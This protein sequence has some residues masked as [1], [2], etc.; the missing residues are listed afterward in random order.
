MDQD[1]EVEAFALPPSSPHAVPAKRKRH[2]K[3]S[4]LPT[5]VD[6][7]EVALPSKPKNKRAKLAKG[8]HEPV[9]DVKDVASVVDAFNDAGAGVE[10]DT[11][12]NV[13][14]AGPT[15]I[16]IKLPKMP[17]EAATTTA[18]IMDE[19]VEDPEAGDVAAEQVEIPRLRQLTDDSWDTPPPREEERKD[20]AG[21]GNVPPPQSD[22]N[23]PSNSLSGPSNVALPPPPSLPGTF[24]QQ[25][26][27]MLRILRFKGDP[28]VPF[29]NSGSPP[30]SH[31]LTPPRAVA[32]A[33]VRP[34]AA[35]WTSL[36]TPETEHTRSNARFTPPRSQEDETERS[37][38]G[39]GGNSRA[40][41][42]EPGHP[43]SDSPIDAGEHDPFPGHRTMFTTDHP[44]YRDG[45]PLEY[46]ADPYDNPEIQG[47]YKTAFQ[48]EPPKKKQVKK[49]RAIRPAS[50]L[51]VGDGSV[52]GSVLDRS[53]MEHEGTPAGTENGE[54]GASVKKKRRV[55]KPP[56]AD[57]PNSIGTW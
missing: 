53:G 30:I 42:E 57:D 47:Q 10:D 24:A 27:N 12:S 18:M 38:L 4:T 54:A 23:P 31:S 19:L 6:G 52:D 11:E 29:V 36:Q 20:I 26:M 16:R 9:A 33:P 43:R 1:E 46:E 17:V 14:T 50:S 49:K 32:H 22:H 35:D 21:I 44:N 51:D 28:N 25:R 5:A 15:T 41:S 45:T 48:P 2:S 40:P 8:P 3:S 7:E 39:R 56:T 37:Y 13:V 55:V 34:E